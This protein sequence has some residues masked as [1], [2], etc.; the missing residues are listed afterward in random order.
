M[1]NIEIIE[2]NTSI[3]ET[4][5]EA[6]FKYNDRVVTMENGSIFV[7]RNGKVMDKISIETFMRK[8]R[9]AMRLFLKN[10]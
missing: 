9:E 1:S 10:C 2:E 4:D 7:S 8:P 3:N 5:A 6:G